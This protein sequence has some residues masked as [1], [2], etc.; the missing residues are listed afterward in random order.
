MMPQ[1][2]TLLQRAVRGGSC[3]W[4]LLFFVPGA[5]GGNGADG[6]R[7]VG[8]FGLSAVGAGL[9]RLSVNPATLDQYLTDAGAAAIY[10]TP[11]DGS[12]TTWALGAVLPNATQS[13]WPE[14]SLDIAV[15]PGGCGPRCAGLE[16][17]SAFAPISP[18]NESLGFVPAIVSRWTAAAG[19]AAPA[20]HVAYVFDCDPAAALS[21]GLPSFCP[22]F[23]ANGTAG[24]S[25]DD[26]RAAAPPP[27]A[28]TTRFCVNVTVT[29]GGE[30][31]GAGAGAGA[32]DLVVG[33]H[34][35]QGAY[36][37]PDSRWYLGLHSPADMAEFVLACVNE[38]AG[39]HADFVAALP[40]TG[41]ATVDGSLRWMTESAVLL[42]KGVGDAA[43]TM[44]CAGG[45]WV[46]G[47][48][49]AA[50]HVFCYLA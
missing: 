33:Y 11:G 37:T 20:F 21:Q 18:R 31:A 42:T 34:S 32:A 13:V 5:E 9:Q 15:I 17:A 1:R 48:G 12:G 39:E 36:A 10:V 47:C 41:N 35:P 27:N 46:V 38:L 7:Y 26:C 30:G 44:G 25:T 50:G 4:P 29:A 40:R 43:L 24:V 23:F 14:L 49:W 16:L 8:N 3:V 28:T 19:A 22:G 2:R 45:A 6:V